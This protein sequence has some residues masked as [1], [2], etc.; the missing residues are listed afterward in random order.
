MQTLTHT[1]QVIRELVQAR[2]F[3]EL[4]RFFDRLEAQ[5]YQAP[6][7][8]FPAYLAALEGHMFADLDNQGDKAPSQVLK[9]WVDACPKAYH[10]HVVMGM[11][12]FHRACRV[13]ADG[14]P[15]AA[16]VLAV[17]QIC[18]TATAHLLQALERS[19]QPLAAAIGM[20]RVSAQLRE[21]GWLA[22]LFNG[23][24]ARYRPSAHADVEVQEAAAP[25]LVRHGVQPLAELPSSL[26]ACL[27]KRTY[28]DIQ[29]PRYYW[30]RHAL[31]LRPGC[32]EAIQA[33][34][35]Y[36]LPRSGAGAD[37]LELLASGP[38]CAGWDERL[39]NA[40]RWMA[41]EE[42]LLLPAADQLQAVATWQQLFDAWAQRPLRPRE[43]AVLL[44]WQGA[45][46]C[47]ALH[48][49]AGA[50]GDFAASLACNADHGAIG[51][52]G[53]PFRCL[54]ELILRDGL[55]DQQQL[56]R[57]ALE[58][59]CDGRCHAGAC[60]LRAAGHCFGLWGLPRSAEQARAW[61][62][63]A[64]KRQLAG[65]APGF[66]VLAAA[67]LLLAANRHEVAVYLY[68]RC[69]ELN[70]P[71]AALGLYDLYCGGQ[72]NTPQEYIDR[73][74]A[75][76]WLRRAVAAGSRRAKYKLACLRMKGSEDLS[77]RSA[78]L[79]V[80]HLL[81]DALG[82]SQTNARARLHLGILL[83]QFGNSR[84]RA[85]A[86][87]YLLSLVEHPDLGIAARASAELGLAWMQG[88]GTR[89]QSRF[90][91]IEWANRAASL[92]PTDAAIARIQAEILNSHNR[93]KTVF[94]QCGAALLRGTLHASELPPRPP[95]LNALRV[96]A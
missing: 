56:L 16:R 22:E 17:G 60:A 39:R 31:G 10:P 92:Q 65:H 15:N 5:W 30:L 67:R 89:K 13:Q 47:T 69:A 66:T 81:V 88:R 78:M 8:E 86:V 2:A 19:A 70:L 64:V 6:P 85:E 55:A 25:L 20:L 87:A 29:D 24:P 41:V 38:L 79:A 34:A 93:V 54:A 21:P 43:R 52:M 7:G 11:H 77:E 91:A 3:V 18:E 95:E 14:Q 96:S 46:R 73:Q 74:A 94:T 1:H 76:H 26:P 33:L 4:T 45:L 32:F 23:R 37:A 84:E 28:Q 53:E 80:R 83:R 9:A 75:E 58:R 63:R 48:D 62:Q 27:A 51:A 90:A 44:A 82:D 49:Q 50:I 68:E 71:G 42:Q 36:L 57:R 12:C 35:I 61:S 72:A 40:L 59:L